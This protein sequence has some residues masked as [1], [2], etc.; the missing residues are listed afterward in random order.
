M[1]PLLIENESHSKA[2]NHA[3]RHIVGEPWSLRIASWLTKNH[4][5]G[6]HRTISIAR[7]FGWLNVVAEYQ[8]TEHVKLD[9]PLYR[10]ANCWTKDDIDA[11]ETEVIGFVR[12]TC[13]QVGGSV[14]LVDCGADIGTFSV[15]CAAQI[16][17]IQRI[18]AFEP[19]SDAYSVLS[20]NL[21]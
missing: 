17:Q 16:P 6:A 13:Q 3:R 5:R 8:L 1:P 9:V 11:Y 10:E 14:T 2:I 19:N 15:L 20:D 18:V 4:L 12:S 21:S 7:R